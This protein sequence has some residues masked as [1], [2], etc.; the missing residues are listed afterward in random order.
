MLL[1]CTHYPFLARTIADIMG[2]E[3]VLVSSGEET[4]FDV[5]AILDSTGLGRRIPSEGKHRFLSSGDPAWFATMGRRLLGPEIATAE[6]V[7]FGA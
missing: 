5:R 2:R 3:V 7:A 4:A 1:G 6:A